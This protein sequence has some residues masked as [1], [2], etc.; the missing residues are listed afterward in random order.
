MN[1][2]NP[3]EYK[4]IAAWGQ[5]MGSYPY[6]IKDQQEDAAQNNAPLD[7]IYRSCG[8]EGGIAEHKGEHTAKC[9]AR[10]A[11]VTNPQTTWY[12]KLNYPEL[13]SK[14]EGE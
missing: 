14:A 12:F 4:H 9:W 6:Y 2:A 8:R 3:K 11:E 7:A 10:F 1:M 13:L 5:M